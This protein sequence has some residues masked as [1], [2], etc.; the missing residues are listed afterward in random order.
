[1]Y[2]EAWLTI[3]VIILMQRFL[4]LTDIGPDTMLIGGVTLLLIPGVLTPAEALS[5]PAS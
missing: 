5:G 3:A 1:M 4:A 2:F